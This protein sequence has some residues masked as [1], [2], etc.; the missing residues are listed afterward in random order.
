MTNDNQQ[1]SHNLNMS[2]IT[3]FRGKDRSLRS[4]LGL[5]TQARES[6]LA[7]SAGT[8]CGMGSPRIKEGRWLFIFGWLTFPS[9]CWFA[10]AVDKRFLSVWKTQTVLLVFARGF[11]KHTIMTYYDKLNL[12]FFHQNS[13]LSV[14]VSFFPLLVL[15]A[16]STTLWFDQTY[17]IYIYMCTY[18]AYMFV[19]VFPSSRE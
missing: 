17:D 13:F 8:W 6:Q 15:T 7:G 2:L 3:C 14:R 9:Y 1:K 11:W 18:T 12:L 19:I 10:N 16:T 5:D 4:A